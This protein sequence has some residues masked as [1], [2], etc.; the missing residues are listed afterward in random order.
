[1]GVHAPKVAAAEEKYLTLSNMHNSHP[2]FSR[3]NE[4]LEREVNI[5]DILYILSTMY[6]ASASLFAITFWKLQF[7]C[8]FLVVV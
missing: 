7:E 3:R 6:N 2:H 1:M 5:V 4:L 8:L